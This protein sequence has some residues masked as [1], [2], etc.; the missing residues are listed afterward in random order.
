MLQQPTI[1]HE[2]PRA[3]YAPGRDC[4]NLPASHLFDHAEHYYATLFHELTHS[5]GHGS[6]LARPTVVNHCPFGSA[7]YSQEELVAEMGAAFLCGHC[8]IENTT[9]DN[10]AAYIHSWLTALRHDSRL[11]IH[12][13]AQAQQAVDFILGTRD[14]PKQCAADSE[15]TNPRLES[16]KGGE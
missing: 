16:E 14:A 3:Y 6:R 15:D 7:D 12:A 4:V 8:G 5:T 2:E 11:L 1:V 10:S 9:I 13:A